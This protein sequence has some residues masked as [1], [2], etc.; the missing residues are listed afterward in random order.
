MTVS[1]AAPARTT[2]SPVT[3]VLRTAGTLG[4]LSLALPVNLAVTGVAWVA[5]SIVR[6]PR[7]TA[8]QPRTV[9]ASGGKMTKALALARSFHAAGHRAVLVESGR[10]RF[11]GHRFSHA[12]DAF[13]VVPKPQ[14][15]EYVE[16]L[17]EIVRNE[18]VDV[19]VPVCSPVASTYDALARDA[20]ATYCE[21]V[22]G[23]P[24]TIATVDDKA[25]FART[26]ASLGLSVPDSHRVEDPRQV[27]ELS[28]AE[29]ALHPQEHPVRPG[30]P[31]RP[32]AAAP[33]HPPR[34]PRG[35]RRPSRSRRR[36]RGCCRS[37]WAGRSTARTWSGRREGLTP[38]R[39]TCRVRGRN[40]RP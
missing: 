18:G 5:S 7:R 16:A 36:R 12:V 19:Y 24:E 38:S 2:R 39:R 8:A 6:P 21:V 27:A 40:E 28:V 13:H 11:T 20:L 9:L 15:P 17:V 4:L 26:A 23:D 25:A 35:S 32:H 22:H 37:P 29:A 10:Y 14:S 34:R 30:Q 3:V 31:A 33:R 1:V